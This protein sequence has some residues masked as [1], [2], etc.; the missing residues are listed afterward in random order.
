MYVH[1]RT[2]ITVCRNVQAD[3]SFEN[4]KPWP[5]FQIIKDNQQKK[6]DGQHKH[7]LSFEEK[8]KSKCF[9]LI[10]KGGQFEVQFQRRWNQVPH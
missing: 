3:S 2:T 1:D 10:E 9:V 6:I 5:T 7:T 8:K 4:I